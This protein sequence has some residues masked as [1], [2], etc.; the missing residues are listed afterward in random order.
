VLFAVVTG[1]SGYS[2]GFWCFLIFGA[3]NVSTFPPI[4]GGVF[5]RS[6]A[7]NVSSFLPVAR[8]LW[9]LGGVVLLEG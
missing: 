9:W 7:G 8:V 6:V 1:F 5:N 4:G 2:Q 3:G